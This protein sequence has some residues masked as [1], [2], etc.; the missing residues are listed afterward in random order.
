M[1]KEMSMLPNGNY[2]EI[3]SPIQ[4]KCSDKD[5]ICQCIEYGWQI[6]KL[7]LKIEHGDPFE[8]GYSTEIDVKYC[9]FCG[10]HSG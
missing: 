6:G 9:P 10:Y 5:Y 8:D 4:H 7:L 1:K 2:E 3:I